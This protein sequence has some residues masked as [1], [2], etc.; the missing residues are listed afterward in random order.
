[1]EFGAEFF[2]EAAGLGE[3]VEFF[4][5]EIEVEIHVAPIV[6]KVGG[7]LVFRVIHGQGAAAHGV[8]EKG[9]IGRIAG[10]PEGAVLGEDEFAHA[11]GG[12]DEVL[13]DQLW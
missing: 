11:E 13:V 10:N 6:G 12:G 9:L 5:L 2:V 1:M 7:N 4:A 3:A 8:E